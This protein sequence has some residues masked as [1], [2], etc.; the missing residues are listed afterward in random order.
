[1]KIAKVIPL[2]KNGNKSAFSNYSPKSLL[3]QF[4]NILGGGK[5]FNERL[6]HFLNTNN[7][8]SN[9]QYGF[10]VHMSTVHAALELTESIYNYIDSKQHCA[11]VFID[12]KKAFDTVNHRLLVDKFY[13]VRGI[14]NTWLEN[15]L[16]NRKQYVVV[17]NQASSMQVIKC[18]VPQGSVI[19][20]V[21]FLL[22]INDLCN[23]S[24]LLKFV[25]F[26][27]DTNISLQ[28]KTWRCF[29]IL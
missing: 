26:A 20:P 27:D 8:L 15:Y 14:A 29:K 1:M 7:I 11:V 24:N 13:G 16:M 21:L 23:M 6:Q 19:G 22:F 5:L 3:S 12:I 25:L 9:S 17:D 18:G 4:S 10:R 2:F 28:M